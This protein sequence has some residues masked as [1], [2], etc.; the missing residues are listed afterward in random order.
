MCVLWEPTPV[1]SCG[2]QQK[3]V[4]SFTIPALIYV[5]IMR[6]GTGS[7]MG[8]TTKKVWKNKENSLNNWL[9]MTM[10]TCIKQKVVKNT[11]YSDKTEQFMH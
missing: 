11:S 9:F 1:L 10:V 5:R 7:I 2:K 3:K 6:F 8:K 4:V